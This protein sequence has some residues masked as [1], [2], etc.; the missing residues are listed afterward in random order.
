MDFTEIT[1]A[2]NTFTTTT[3][4]QHCWCQVKFPFKTL[5]KSNFCE[6]MRHFAQNFHAS[7]VRLAPFG[8]RKVVSQFGGEEVSYQF[9]AII[10][11]KVGTHG[12]MRPF[13]RYGRAARASENK[14]RNFCRTARRAVPTKQG[15]VGTHGSPRRSLAKPG[16]MRPF[17]G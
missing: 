13:I 11:A 2:V 8:E 17:I 7:C 4:F 12:L 16:L 6:S 14:E 1:Y 9:P 15:E 3:G 5:E 10:G